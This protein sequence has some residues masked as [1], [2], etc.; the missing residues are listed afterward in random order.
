MFNNTHF[1]GDETALRETEP[2]IIMIWNM[3]LT[4]MVSKPEFFIAL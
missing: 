2:N 3:W 1:T 4:F